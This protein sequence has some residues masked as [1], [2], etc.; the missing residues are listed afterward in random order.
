MNQEQKRVVEGHLSAGETVKAARSG[1]NKLIAV[2][3]S[4]LLTITEESNA[5][6]DTRKV[7]STL[8][9]G[10][11]VVGAR[12]ERVGS[13][14]VDTVE[15]AL[16]FVLGIIGALA[17]AVSSSL[18]GGAGALGLLVGLGILAG[19][20][21]VCYS[22]ITTDGEVEATILTLDDE[23]NYSVTLPEDSTGVARAISTV[24]GSD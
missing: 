12:V 13:G 19:G 1:P 23:P 14:S 8:L 11:H 3:D 21:Y 15:F 5:G 22:A 20:G 4:R 17:L 9:T 2:T 16:G 6:K 18:D 10:Q 24:V 7:E